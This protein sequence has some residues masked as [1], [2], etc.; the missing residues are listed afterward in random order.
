MQNSKEGW[1]LRIMEMDLFSG[2]HPDIMGKIA[3]ICSEEHYA[4]G[5]TIFKEGDAAT[6]LYILEQG[7]V[8]LRIRGGTP[9]YSLSETG[10]LF[11]WSSLVETAEYTASAIC[12]TDIQAIKIETTRLNKIFADHPDTGLAFYRRLSGV[13]NQR[14]ANIYQKFL[15]AGR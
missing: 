11:G 5:I 3:D 8:E 7:T 10:S 1:E 14:L 13:F 2:I 4:K 9:V 15:S 12:E 6:S